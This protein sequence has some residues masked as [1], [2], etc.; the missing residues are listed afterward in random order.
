MFLI[1]IES[2]ETSNRVSPTRDLYVTSASF[3]RGK[4]V[5]EA[6]LTQADMNEVAKCRRDHNRL[7]FAYQIGFARQVTWR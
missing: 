4:L 3:S 7:G 1:D 6:S 2:G 5:R